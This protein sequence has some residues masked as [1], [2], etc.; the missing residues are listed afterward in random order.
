M[1]HPVF[2][3]A[4]LSLCLSA[5]AGL[6]LVTPPKRLEPLPDA[7][8][9]PAVLKLR[10]SG[11][12]SLSIREIRSCCGCLTAAA[13]SAAIAPGAEFELPFTYDA[14]GRQGLQKGSL[15]LVPVTG[16][17]LVVPI[18]VF[19]RRSFDAK[20]RLLRWKKDTAEAFLEAQIEVDASLAPATPRICTPSADFPA[21][22]RPGTRPGQ[23]ILRV[24][25]A[26][27]A[28]RDSLTLELPLPGAAATTIEV[29]LSR[30]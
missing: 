10:N 17:A 23:W 7:T 5:W 1:K 6:E 3:A 18:E 14:K 30:E 2:V 29:F 8:R 4:G 28:S 24:T 13:P 20:P 12:D 11:A 26:T 16:E 19:L 21:E 22:L 25:Q 27:R 15:T 9:I